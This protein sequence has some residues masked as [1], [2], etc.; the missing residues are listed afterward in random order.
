[1][2]YHFLLYVSIP[3]INN[4]FSSFTFYPLLNVVRLKYL[5]HFKKIYI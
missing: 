3:I 2:R 1:M 4:Y 5:F